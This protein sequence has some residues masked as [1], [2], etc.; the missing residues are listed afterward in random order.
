MRPEL[1]L[2]AHRPAASR[3]PATGAAAQPRTDPAARPGRHPGGWPR[4]RRRC[5]RFATGVTYGLSAVRLWPISTHGNNAPP[6]KR[7]V[8]IG[9]PERASSSA[10]STVSNATHQALPSFSCPSVESTMSRELGTA[11]TLPVTAAD[12]VATTDRLSS[13]LPPHAPAFDAPVM[14][15]ARPLPSPAASGFGRSS[16]A[17]PLAR[18]H[19]SAAGAGWSAHRSARPAP[20]CRRC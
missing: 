9:S 10:L 3:T 16:T 5:S 12:T 6:I 7:S 1:A 2:R 15:A 20:C 8:P 19:A 13:W 18:R 14:T 4:V 17:P 11:R